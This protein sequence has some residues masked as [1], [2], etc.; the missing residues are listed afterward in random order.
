MSYFLIGLVIGLVCGLL[1]CK[2]Q[3]NL[4]IH[5]GRHEM[6]TLYKKR[7]DDYLNHGYK[8]VKIKEKELKKI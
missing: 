7:L 6:N 8:L 4:G 3:Y 1:L 2:K 5:V